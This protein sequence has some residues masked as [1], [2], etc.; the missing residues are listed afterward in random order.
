MTK[1]KLNSILAF[2]LC[3]CIYTFILGES[4]FGTLSEVWALSSDISVNDTNDSNVYYVPLCDKN[5]NELCQ[6]QM[7]GDYARSYYA[8]GITYQLTLNGISVEVSK[9]TDLVI[10]ISVSDGSYFQ[11][12]AFDGS[13]DYVD[14]LG[15]ICGVP[16]YQIADSVFSNYSDIT[17][18]A[19]RAFQ[20][21]TNMQVITIP[22]SVTDIGGSAFLGCKSLKSIKLPKSLASLPNDGKYGFFEECTSLSSITIPDS[23]TEIGYAAFYHCNSLTEIVVPDSVNKIGEWCFSECASLEAVQLPEGLETIPVGLFKDSKSLKSVNIPQSVTSIEEQ[24]FNNCSSLSSMI[25]PAT[26]SNFSFDVF[27]GCIGLTALNIDERHSDYTSVNGVVYNKELNSLIYCPQGCE[28]YVIPDGVTEI[29]GFGG[30]VLKDVIIPES[31]TTIKSYAF[32]GCSSLE[33]IELPASITKIESGAFSGCSA[34]K[35]IN[36]P[37]GVTNIESYTFSGCTSLATMTVPNGVH[38]ETYTFW[39]N[40]DSALTDIYY[41]GTSSEWYAGSKDLYLDYDVVMV[42]YTQE[43][44]YMNML[45]Y[46]VI[47]DHIEISHWRR[48]KEKIIIPFEIDGLPVKSIAGKAFEQEYNLRK[49]VIPDGITNIGE[50]AFYA[51]TNLTDITI[52]NS[53]TSLGYSTFSGCTK[54]EYATLSNQLTSIETYT[55]YN[56]TSLKSIKI[57]EG[58]TSIDSSVFYGCESLKSV[59]LPNTLKSIGYDSFVGCISLTD[60]YFNGTEEQWN[61]IEIKSGNLPLANA[62]I[63]YNYTPIKGDVNID[64]SL[65]IADVVLLQKW[66]LAVPDTKLPD[67][68]A[69]DL[70]SD[71][72]LDVFDLCLMKRALFNS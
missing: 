53:V 19:I 41:D 11:A 37:E 54:L 49:I 25:I 22:N 56:C 48:N 21:C 4:G 43:N 5:G 2:L 64:G 36:I 55:F 67:W 16:M 27:S 51:C 8:D 28:K 34:L 72:R 15:E 32:R 30:S 60:V 58:V 47:D 24:A 62:T 1:K 61:S 23:V 66:L 31:V 39:N 7:G 26:L 17:E 65:N 45:L 50:L 57:P 35:K 12:V 20:N 71:N 18:I 63:H 38:F 46:E 59:I 10:R 52:P 69:A 9:E 68:K 29:D 42:H 44:L 33:K 40:G 3:G 70:C 13:T 14:V 6:L